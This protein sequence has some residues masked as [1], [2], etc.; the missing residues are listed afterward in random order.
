MLTF[1]KDE[2]YDDRWHADLGKMMPWPKL[3]DIIEWL[4]DAQFKH[5]WSVETIGVA[6]LSP[7]TRAL[8]YE[9]KVMF[10]SSAERD[11]FE[12]RWKDWF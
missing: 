7:Q 11:A 2:D 4:N 1:T 3:R 6:R 10:E 8:A 12:A 9:V 5:G